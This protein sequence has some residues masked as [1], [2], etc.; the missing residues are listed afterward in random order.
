MNAVTNTTGHSLIFSSHLES[1]RRS[2]YV[3][4]FNGDNRVRVRLKNSHFFS[5]A[6]SFN[7]FLTN[8]HTSVR[9]NPLKRKFLIAQEL[10]VDYEVVT[11]ERRNQQ[12]SFSTNIEYMALL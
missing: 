3:Y 12:L 5:F 1:Q 4:N 11:F 10:I 6:Q 9:S 8:A 7:A 2:S